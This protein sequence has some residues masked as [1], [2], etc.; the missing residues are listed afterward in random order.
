LAGDLIGPHGVRVRLDK[1][2]TCVFHPGNRMDLVPG[3]LADLVETNR[4]GWLTCHQ[5]LRS[6]T[7]RHDTAAVCKGWED[8]YG[9]GEGVTVL[10][11]I[12][13]REDVS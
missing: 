1:C 13:G 11:A 8:A 5:T 10:V 7:G 4:G 3:R 2:T 12:F 6:V 9:L